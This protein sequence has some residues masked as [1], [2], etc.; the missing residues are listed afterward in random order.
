MPGRKLQLKKPEVAACIDEW[1]ARE[2]DGWRKTRLL[3]VKL[4]ARGESTSAQIADLCG[5]ARGHLFVWLSIVRERGIEALLERG[6]PGPQEGTCRGVAPQVIA[7]LKAKLQA[8]E[9]ANAQQARR[10][11]KKEHGIDRPYASVWN[12]LK[13]IRRSAEGAAS[14]SLRKKAGSAGAVQNR[15]VRKARKPRT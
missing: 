10:W 8:H 1:H 6:Q 9:F 3:A 14:Q 7:Q 4:A 2:P 11:L 13:K 5:I 15:A 12:W